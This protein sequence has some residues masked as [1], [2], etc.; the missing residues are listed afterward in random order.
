MLGGILESDLSL[1]ANRHLHRLK[2]KKKD[3][4]PSPIYQKDRPL[5]QMIGLA[6]LRGRARAL[7]F[8][9][10]GDNESCIVDGPSQTFK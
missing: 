9:Y 10:T 1:E 6:V 7:A 8:V 3:L 5:N 2:Q 4:N